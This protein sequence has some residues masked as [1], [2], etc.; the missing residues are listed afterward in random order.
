LD[1]NNC[2]LLVREEEVDKDVNHLLNW[3]DTNQYIDKSQGVDSFNYMQNIGEKESVLNIN[4]NL[5]YQSSQATIGK[6]YDI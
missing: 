3:E 4:D 2:S 6:Q 5:N 1:A